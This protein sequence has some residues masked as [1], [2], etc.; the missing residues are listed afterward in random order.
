MPSSPRCVYMHKQSPGWTLCMVPTQLHVHRGHSWMQEHHHKGKGKLSPAADKVLV[1]SL[2][3]LLMHGD[4][5]WAQ[6]G[7][8]GDVPWHCAKVTGHS[9]KQHQVNLP[10]ET[11]GDVMQAG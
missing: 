11:E 4:H 2:V 8:C 9:W 7:H 3:Q 6:L 10:A 5:P 1:H